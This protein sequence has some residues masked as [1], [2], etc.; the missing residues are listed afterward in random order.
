M[1]AT[2][3]DGN[4]KPTGHI[5]YQTPFGMFWRG[6]GIIL[7]IAV[8]GFVALLVWGSY[9]GQ[10]NWKEAEA[11]RQ[12]AEVKR[13][14]FSADQRRQGLHYYQVA[15]QYAPIPIPV[16]GPN[17]PPSID[18]ILGVPSPT[19]QNPVTYFGF[20]WAASPAEARRDIKNTDERITGLT[21]QSDRDAVI[22]LDAVPANEN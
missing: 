21:Y 8:I 17:D 7:L 6:V 15:W 3:Y 19:P 16:K 12:V 13:Q 10:Q 1:K 20:V 5:S 4:G 11:E 14:A 18:E 22:V 2:I 9:L